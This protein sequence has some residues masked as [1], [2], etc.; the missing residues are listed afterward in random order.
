MF[1]CTQKFVCDFKWSAGHFSKVYYF[2]QCS[3]RQQHPKQFQSSNANYELVLCTCCRCYQNKFCTVLI[4]MHIFCCA[5][6]LP[7]KMSSSLYQLSPQVVDIVCLIIFI[8]THKI[9]R[10]STQIFLHFQLWF[11]QFTFIWI[12]IILCVWFIFKFGR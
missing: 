3:S 8:F 2:Y 11:A 5:S 9:S 6:A 7:N 12:F 1:H 4:R 10:Y